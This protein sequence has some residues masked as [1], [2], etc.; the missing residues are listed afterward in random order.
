M[1]RAHFS[2]RRCR[3]EQTRIVGEDCRTLEKMDDLA[4]EVVEKTDARIGVDITRLAKS[5]AVS[6]FNLRRAAA[7]NLV[8]H[9]FR[10]R[11]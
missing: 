6:L 10:I 7:G 11:M 5:F 1:R 3:E 8:L 4:S 9:H 2:L